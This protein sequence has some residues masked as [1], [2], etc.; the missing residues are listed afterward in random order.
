MGESH[1][2]FRRPVQLEPITN[3]SSSSQS[4]VLLILADFQ[5]LFWKIYIF[6]N[7]FKKKQEVT[8]YI[9]QR[10]GLVATKYL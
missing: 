2:A 10:P 4:L 7:F 1:P 5:K 3:T 6:K 8:T 9:K